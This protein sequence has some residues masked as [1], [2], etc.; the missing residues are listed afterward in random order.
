MENAT[1][2][3]FCQKHPPL[4]LESPKKLTDLVLSKNTNSKINLEKK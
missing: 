1:I 4:I 3:N 2:I